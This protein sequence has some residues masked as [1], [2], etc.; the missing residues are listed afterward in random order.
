[1]RS[2]W[3]GSIEIPSITVKWDGCVG[4]HM[5]FM[6]PPLWVRWG[7]GGGGSEQK[8]K[9]HSSN[10]GHRQKGFQRGEGHRQVRGFSCSFRGTVRVFFLLQGGVKDSPE[11]R[12]KLQLS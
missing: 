7:G 10:Q 8:P 11:K 2:Q 6:N 9:K 3:A 4:F 12:G 1:M 5:G